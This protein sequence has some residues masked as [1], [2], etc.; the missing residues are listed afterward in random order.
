MAK[1]RGT[2]AYES[3]FLVAE[4]L[5]L[6]DRA[7]AQLFLRMAFNVMARNCDDHTKNSAFL[8]REGDAWELTPAF[9]VTHAY[10]P[11]GEW[12]Y[13]HLMSVNGKFD[14]IRCA[15]LTAVGDRFSVPRIPVLLDQVTDAAARWTDFAA[16][17]GLPAGE[18]DKVA[19]DHRLLHA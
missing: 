14:H 17:A 11:G 3:L 10:N 12:T 6:D 19:N 5:S 4:R 16:E 8:L 18:A 2:H 13:Q 1:Q 15:D 9:D 7:R